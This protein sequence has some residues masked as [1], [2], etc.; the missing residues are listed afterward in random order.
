M[1][2]RDAKFWVLEAKGRKLERQALAFRA[3]LLPHLAVKDRQKEVAQLNAM[4]LESEYD[5]DD[6]DRM[7]REAQEKRE[8]DRLAPR[9]KRKK[10]A[11]AVKHG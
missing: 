3:A 10:R 8:R 9:K 7:D 2:V 6:I 4:L 1:G 5:P 11:K